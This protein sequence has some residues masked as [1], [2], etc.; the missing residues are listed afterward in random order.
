[1]KGNAQCHSFSKHGR[2]N[3]D[4]IFGKKEVVRVK[5]P[6]PQGAIP[7]DSSVGP[8]VPKRKQTEGEIK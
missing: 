6:E 1:M 3:Y 2:D 8:A 4:A 7:T 5:A